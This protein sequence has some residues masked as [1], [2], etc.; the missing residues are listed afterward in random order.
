MIKISCKKQ[1]KINYHI[2]KKALLNNKTFHF[3]YLILGGL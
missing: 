2:G 1:E 3:L